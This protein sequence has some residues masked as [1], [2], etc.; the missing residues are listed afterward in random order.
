MNTAELSSPGRAKPFLKWAGGKQQLLAQFEAHFPPQFE[1]YVEPFIGGGAVFF[2]LWNTRRLPNAVH[3]FLFDTNEELI[4]T[5]RVVKSDVER[6]IDL[7]QK[8]QRKHC[9]DYYYQVRH[10]DREDVE[11]TDA[12]RAARMIYLNKT[13]YNGLYRVNRQGQFNVPIGSYQHPRIFDDATLRTTSVSLRHAHL[14]VRDFRRVVEFAQAG[15]FVYFD[16]PYHPMSSTSSFTNYTA[17]SF[18]D[19]DQRDLADVFRALDRKGCFCML[20]NSSTDLIHQ[21]YTDDFRVETVTA[22]RNINSN[23]RRR[24]SIQEV[25]VLNY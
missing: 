20:S 6:L 18:G 12:A 9:K 16:P 11:W 7:L 10:W 25:V 3:A 5:Y 4:T 15:D 8:H 1:R 24:G 21:L 19:A 23:G 22:N 2:H 17:S 14:E 13:C